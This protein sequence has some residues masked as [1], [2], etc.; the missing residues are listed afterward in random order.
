MTISFK[1]LIA[2]LIGSG[3]AC[4]A[5]AASPIN[6]TFLGTYDGTGRA[7]SGFVRLTSTS[8]TWHASFQSISNSPFEV[9]DQRV[10][11]K[12]IKIAIRLKKRSKRWDLPIVY[13][14]HNADDPKHGWGIIGFTSIHAYRKFDTGDTLMCP[15]VKREP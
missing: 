7:C 13:L 2:Y 15:L 3:L 10:D 6:P 8:F 12:G 14:E 9:I 5:M 4:F 1:R 11:D